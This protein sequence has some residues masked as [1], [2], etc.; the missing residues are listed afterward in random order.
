MLAVTADLASA[1]AVLR[2]TEAIDVALLDIN[3]R[4]EMVFELADD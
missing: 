1:Q 2:A 4:G 3:N